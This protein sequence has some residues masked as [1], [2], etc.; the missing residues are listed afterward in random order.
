[1]DRAA[2]MDGTI[3]QGEQEETNSTRYTSIKYHEWRKKCL[4]HRSAQTDGSTGSRH[5][6]SQSG[7]KIPVDEQNRR[8]HKLN[9]RFGSVDGSKGRGKAWNEASKAT[10]QSPW[11]QQGRAGR[12]QGMWGEEGGA[13]RPEGAGGLRLLY[14]II[15][16]SGHGGILLRASIMTSARHTCLGQWL[17][18]ACLLN[19]CAGLLILSLP[20]QISVSPRPRA[21]AR[22]KVQRWWQFAFRTAQK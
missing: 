4:N 6:N 13:A 3:S 22:L 9:L 11:A 14:T 18:G 19:Y 21:L 10:N 12:G 1:M 7:D 8:I 5:T 17:G 16:L 15:N 20:H 2:G